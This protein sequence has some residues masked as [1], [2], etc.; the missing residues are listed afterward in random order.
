MKGVVFTEFQELVETQFGLEIYDE[1]VTQ[2]ELES[3]G[4]YTAVGTYDHQELIRM[5]GLLSKITNTAADDLVHAFGKFL[6]SCFVAKYSVF[7]ENITSAIPLLRSVDQHIHVEVR[8]LYPEAELPEF[9]FEDLPNG[10]YQMTYSSSLPFAKLAKGLIEES[11]LHFNDP[12]QVECTSCSD[13]MTNATFLISP[14][15]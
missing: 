8:K 10:D 9:T 11:I 1:I 7:F 6:F 13:D 14:K 12:L 2:A 15:E 5:V 4:A 3:E